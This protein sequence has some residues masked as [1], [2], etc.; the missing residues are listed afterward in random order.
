MSNI[1]IYC[2]TDK[3][4]SFL[5]NLTYEIG[6]VGRT[7]TPKNYIECN[8][9]DNIFFKEKYYSELTFHYWYWKNL[10]DLNVN[11]DWVGFCQKR[12][13]WSNTRTNN[14]KSHDISSGNFFLNKAPLSWKNYD[15]IICD[16]IDLNN[17]NIIKIFKR[18]FRSVIRDPLILF[19]KNR[20]TIK[21]H[22]D[23]HHG[24]DNLIKAANLLEKEDRSDFIEYINV[25]T[26]FHPHIMFIAKPKIVNL[27][28]SA[29][30]PW[31]SRCEKLFG[32]ENL[33]GYDTQRLY[34]YLAERYLSFW[35]KKHTKSLSHPW[36]FF[37]T[38]TNN[39]NEK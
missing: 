31:L 11:K 37:D 22:F 26:S 20:R 19:D 18:G 28:F 34:A 25:S 29:L 17:V 7:E 8:K 2:V 27:W 39:I 13:F 32:F 5:D 24:F 30:F 15:S 21:L 23:M 33:N 14:I 12:R 6:W 10:Q 4:V 1:K 38:L 9:K 3:E 35:F 16:P 36:I